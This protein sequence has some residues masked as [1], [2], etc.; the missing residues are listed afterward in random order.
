VIAAAALVAA[1]A[2]SWP[3]PVALPEAGWTCFTVSPFVNQTVCV[4]T[5]P[6][7]QGGCEVNVGHCDDTA[8]CT[9]NVGY[10]GGYG[11]CLVNVGYCTDGTPVHL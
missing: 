1:A 5:A 10:C 8:T 11:S 9:V 4:N 2:A 6:A 7:G 3:H